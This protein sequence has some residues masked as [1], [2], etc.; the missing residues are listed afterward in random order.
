M[1]KP[2][3]LDEAI[4]RTRF[5]SKPF[6]PRK[7]DCRRWTAILNAVIFEGKV[8][9]YRAIHIHKMK[10]FGRFSGYV[11]SKGKRYGELEMNDSFTSFKSFF[12]ILS[13]ELCHACDYSENETC[14]H[15]DFFYS[16]KQILAKF[17]VKLNVEYSDT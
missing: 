7:V 5:N 1:L 17:G 13:H 16:H 6:F 14:T 9:P 12:S 15:G 3:D 11:N 2:S 4:L 10:C 8:P